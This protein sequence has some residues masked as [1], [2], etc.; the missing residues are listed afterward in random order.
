LKNK[1][2]KKN[3][4]NTLTKHYTLGGYDLLTEKMGVLNLKIVC[5]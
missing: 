5:P 3:Y 2:I 1:L 4:D